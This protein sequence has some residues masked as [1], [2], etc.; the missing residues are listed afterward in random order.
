MV[1]AARGVVAW[2]ASCMGKADGVCL[3]LT[4]FMRLSGAQGSEGG[5]R[6]RAEK[7]R[8]DHARLSA[9]CPG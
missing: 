7:G 1:L 8:G 3:A 6:Q 2:C 9:L 5:E 4:A